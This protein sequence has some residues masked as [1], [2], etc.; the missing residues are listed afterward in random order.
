[1]PALLGI[2]GDQEKLKKRMQ[3]MKNDVIRYML[4]PLGPT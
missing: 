3:V 2:V 1:M 4:S